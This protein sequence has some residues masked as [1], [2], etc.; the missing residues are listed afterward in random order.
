MA[1]PAEGVTC[2]G[3]THHWSGTP[4]IADGDSATCLCGGVTVKLESG[5]VLFITTQ[6]VLEKVLGEHLDMPFSFVSPGEPG[7]DVDH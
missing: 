2:E 4:V 7:A 3:L 5:Q 1:E 6:A